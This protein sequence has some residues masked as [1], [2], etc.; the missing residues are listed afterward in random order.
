MEL[1]DSHCHFDFPA[2]DAD[3]AEVRDRC[4]EQGLTALV[5][6]GV[7]AATWE[8]AARM[9]AEDP[10]LHHAEGLHPMF[11]DAHD[12]DTDLVTLECRLEGTSAGVRPV[13]IGEIG[14]DFRRPPVEHAA[15]EALLDAQL[16]IARDHRLPAII[17]CVR[18]H[19]RLVGR[20]R[21]RGGP[22]GV[23]HAFNGSAEDARAYVDSG[24]HLGIGG[25]ITHERNRRL[26]DIVAGLPAE[27][28]LL[29]TDAP[30]MPPDGHAGERNSPENL[31]AIAAA[32]AECR[33]ER[34]EDV[35]GYTAANTRTLFGLGST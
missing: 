3:R 28:L 9:A 31:P 15:Q 23:I 33:G 25:L 5:I 24:F 20:L 10:L 13:A 29:E 2:F 12:P 18:A 14:L 7:T 4:V 16:A 19:H 30:D 22:G 27:A 34:V 8:R 11:S 6:P 21:R 32:V 1:A 26:R 17:H 35:A